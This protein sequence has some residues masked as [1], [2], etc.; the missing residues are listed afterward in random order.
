MSQTSYRK[1]ERR[2]GI[3]LGVVAG[4]V[5]M[6]AAGAAQ[7]TTQTITVTN[8]N[9][10]GSGS[11]R[12]AINTANGDTGDTINFNI[13]TG[14]GPFTITLTTGLLPEITSSM[15]IVGPTAPSSAV[16]I[17]GGGNSQLFWVNRFFHHP[18]ATLNL[19]YLTLANGNVGDAFPGLG[20]GGA[21]FNGGTLTITGCTFLDNNAGGEI[22][23]GGA[24]CNFGQLTITGCTFLDNKATGVAGLGGA[25]SNG[26][27]GA[28]TNSTF[29]GNEAI[30]SSQGFGD[31][32]AIL[33]NNLATLTI[34][35]ATFSGNEAI[36]GGAFGGAVSNE[37]GSTVDYKGTILA[38]N[39][40][41][42]CAGAP[43]DNGYNIDDDGSCGFSATGSKSNFTTLSTYLDQLGNN[44]GPTMTI[45]EL[46]GQG[47]PTIDAIPF[48]SCTYPSGSLNP[49]RNPPSITTSDQLICDQRGF[50]RPDPKDGARGNCDIGAYEFG[51]IPPFEIG[52]PGK[53]NCH[54]KSVSALAQ[55]YGGMNAAASALGYPSVGDLQ[56]AIKD[57]C[58][59]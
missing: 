25:I 31:G 50:G 21:I 52:V 36:G 51:A 29:S 55:Q 32:G 43:V 45:K 54:G 33:N 26:G 47:N 38:A 3:L 5:A 9:D 58:A 48:A 56:T 14:T 35:N 6:L 20:L 17:S 57:Y 19:Q 37:G 39:T 18:G 8:T 2:V 10:S 46:P 12:D 7:A 34:T 13:S 41:D 11:L 22:A 28:I 44:G 16:T 4:I 27:P 1:M 15:T 49:C 40:P 53:P 30:G 59:G 42:N 23:D 24:I